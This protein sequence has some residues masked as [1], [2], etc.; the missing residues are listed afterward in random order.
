MSRLATRWDEQ[1]SYLLTPALAAYEMERLT[2]ASLG[3]RVSAKIK[4]NVPEGHTR[5]YPVVVN[6]QS[7]EKV[8]EMFK[9]AQIAS[10]IMCTRGD[11]VNIALRVKIVTYPEMSA[12][13]G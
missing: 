11:E 4:R 10:D 6:S 7:P 12:Q 9:K 8:L 1:L 5:G 13:F 2:G 3:R